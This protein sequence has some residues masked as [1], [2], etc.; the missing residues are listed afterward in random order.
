MGPTQL[1]LTDVRLV[2]S[3]SLGRLGLLEGRSLSK[4]G[5]GLA[6]SGTHLPEPPAFALLP[7]TITPNKPPPQTHAWGAKWGFEAI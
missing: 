4:K 2:M 6:C 5:E 7:S 3:A 1:T